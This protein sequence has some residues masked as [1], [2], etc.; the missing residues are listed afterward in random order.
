VGEAAGRVEVERARPPN[1][2]RASYGNGSRD[3]QEPGLVLLG[4][5]DELDE[6]LRQCGNVGQRNPQG[7]QLI[8]CASALEYG[9]GKYGLGGSRDLGGEGGSDGAEES[10]EDGHRPRSHVEVRRLAH[11][12]LFSAGEIAG[13]NAAMIDYGK[14]VRI[15]AGGAT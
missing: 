15:S 8:E 11:T 12:T 3:A 2:R 5:V 7:E 6:L 4:I 13:D 9:T 1:G 10:L 14:Q